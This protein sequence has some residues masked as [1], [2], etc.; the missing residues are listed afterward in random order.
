MSALAWAEP[1]YGSSS[2]SGF[3]NGFSNGLSNGLSTG[4]NNGFSNGFNNG[5]FNNGFN[6]G[7]VSRP[8]VSY[9]KPTFTNSYQPSSF[10][11]SR[12]RPSFSFSNN[13]RRPSYG[14]YRRR[15]KR[16]ADETKETPN[17]MFDNVESYAQDFGYDQTD[18]DAGL[19]DSSDSIEDLNLVKR[20]AEAEP[21]YPVYSYGGRYA[22]SRPYVGY[23]FGGRR[24]YFGRGRGYHYW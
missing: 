11:P 5:G 4:F 1:Q 6:N 8:A 23:G 12:F 17:N 21:H 19:F 15:G 10:R 16:D 24:G 14:G 3:N 22:Y 9:Q 20:E 18:F 7:F 13:F 2:S